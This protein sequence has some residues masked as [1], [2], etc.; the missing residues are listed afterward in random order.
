MLALIY[1]PTPAFIFFGSSGREV[2]KE[3]PHELKKESQG[4]VLSY[5]I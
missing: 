2:R 1:Q 5:C 4:W 3:L